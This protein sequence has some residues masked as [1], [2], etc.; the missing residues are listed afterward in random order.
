MHINLPVKTLVHVI[1]NVTACDADEKLVVHRISSLLT[2]ESNDVVFILDRGDA[3][4]FDAVSL[5]AIKKSNAGVF[6]AANPVV[7]GK[8]YI[9]VKDALVAFEQLVAYITKQQESLHIQQRIGENVS[10]DHTAV[11]SQGASIG[12]GTKIGAHVFVG[13]CCVIGSNVFLHP[14]V[15]ILDRC[16]LGDNTIVQA[17]AVIGSDGFGYQVSKT[18]LRKIPQIGVVRIGNNVE[19]GANCTIDRASFEETI[20]GDGVKMD[21]G[22]HIAHNVKVGAHTV[23]LAQTGIAGSA[24]IGMGC[25]IGGQVAIRDHIKIGN[26]VKIVSK[27]AVLNDLKDGETVCGVPAIPFGQWKRLTVALSKVP[28]LMKNMKGAKVAFNGARKTLWQRLFG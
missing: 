12:A 23:I 17:G 10:I 6:V 2:A 19:V 22:V 8:K 3:S 16:V 14:G 15:K 11:I 25:Q 26:N 18:G 13:S 7:P 28:D 5:D 4:V 1:D 27:S 24:E 20:V 21:N 9:I